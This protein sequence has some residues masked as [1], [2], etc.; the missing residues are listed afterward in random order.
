MCN[1]N[2]DSKVERKLKQDMIATFKSLTRTDPYGLRNSE[3][4]RPYYKLGKNNELPS[5][6]NTPWGDA[7]L[8]LD[9]ESGD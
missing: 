5:E 4:A 8:E 3:G 1:T 6:V 7:Q 9:R 2:K